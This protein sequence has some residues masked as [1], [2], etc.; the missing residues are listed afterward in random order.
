MVT[1]NHLKNTTES[2][3]KNGTLRSFWA[4][5]QGNHQNFEKNDI[6]YETQGCF[7]WKKSIS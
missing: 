1:D 6:S 5:N 3:E 7:Y 4:G 2:R